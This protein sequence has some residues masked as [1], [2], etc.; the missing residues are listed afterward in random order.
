MDDTSSAQH[1]DP[2]VRR[3]LATVGTASW[4]AGGVGSFVSGNA[5]GA[6]ALVVAGAAASLIA[7]TGRWPRRISVYG[8][9]LSWDDVDRTVAGQIRV[10]RDSGD[11]QIVAELHELQRRLDTLRATG[12][13]PPHPAELYDRAVAAALRRVAPDVALDEPGP[14]RRG[15]PDFVLRDGG[16]PVHVETKWRPEGGGV[17]HGSTLPELLGALPA[18]E[19]VLVV[20]N[21]AVVGEGQRQLGDRGVAVAWRDPSDDDALADAVSRL[22]HR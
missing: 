20:T 10:A 21:A 2:R 19:R 15:R 18:D 12:Q 8:N 17:F 14:H 13:V 22:V 5:G 4:L 6:A 7:A 16:R 9:E 3:T 1:L 11:E